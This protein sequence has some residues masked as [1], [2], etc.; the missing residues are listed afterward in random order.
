MTKTSLPAIFSD[1]KFLITAAAGIFLVHS[2]LN[3]LDHHLQ[4][5]LVNA[6]HEYQ[7][8]KDLSKHGD[9]YRQK[10]MEFLSRSELPQSLRMEQNEWIRVTQE[11]IGRHNLALKALTPQSNKST[12][13]GDIKLHVVLDG[14]MTDLLGFLYQF[15]QTKDWVYVSQFSLSR[16]EDAQNV[17]AEMILSQK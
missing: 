13:A 4:K 12:I 7:T 6:R 1:K 2:L 14:A 11:M 15:T 3:S 16:Q 8:D 10:Y 17:Q 5:S 9:E